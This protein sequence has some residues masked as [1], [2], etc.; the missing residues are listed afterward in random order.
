MDNEISKGTWTGTTVIAII[1]VLGMAFA[2]FALS[3][4]ILNKG[5]SDFAKQIDNI[6]ASVYEDYDGAIVSGMKVRSALND[7]DGKNVIIMINTQAV[8]KH[9]AGSNAT[10]KAAN[11]FNGTLVKSKADLVVK[12]NYGNKNLANSNTGTNE[13]LMVLQY[14]DRAYCV[15]GALPTAEGKFTANEKGYVEYN[16]VFMTD[17]SGSV[18]RNSIKTNWK[19]QGC[20]EYISNSSNF[21]A[22]LIKDATDTIVGIVFT[23]DYTISE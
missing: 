17:S 7:F 8:Q 19:T 10:T 20:T 11:K 16:D 23:Q 5:Q 3:R 12:E 14:N 15:Y 18:V 4:S 6:D 21:D 1:G 9:F 13:G 22:K 2:V